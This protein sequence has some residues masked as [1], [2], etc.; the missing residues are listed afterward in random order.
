M[1]TNIFQMMDGWM[2]ILALDNF[3][4]HYRKIIMVDMLVNIQNITMYKSAHRA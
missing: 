3:L 2:D 1:I 4:G